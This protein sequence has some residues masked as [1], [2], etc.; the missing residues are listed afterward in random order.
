MNFGVTGLGDIFWWGGDFWEFCWA[1]VEIGW[2][3][4]AVI[5]K[6]YCCFLW[7]YWGWVLVVEVWGYGVLG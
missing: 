5:V 4:V 1:M 2:D 3:C 6:K 7:G